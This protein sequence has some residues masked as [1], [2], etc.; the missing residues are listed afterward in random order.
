MEGEGRVNTMDDDFTQRTL[1]QLLTAMADKAELDHQIATLIR[2]LADAHGISADSFEAVSARK[3]LD[4]EPWQAVVSAPVRNDAG[5]WLLTTKY[6]TALWPHESLPDARHVFLKRSE[7][8][9][10]LVDGIYDVNRKIHFRELP[11]AE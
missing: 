2:A 6:T 11:P 1:M 10:Y 9:R 4:A 8:G 7:N 5:G 3:I